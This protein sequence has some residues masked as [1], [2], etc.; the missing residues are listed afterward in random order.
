M[1][2]DLEPGGEIPGYHENY[3]LRQDRY[4]NLFMENFWPREVIRRVLIPFLVTRQLFAG[5]GA[6]VSD[7]TDV[8]FELSQRA[9]WIETVFNYTA[10]H[11][12]PIL[13][14]KR[15]DLSEKYLRVH[16]SCGDPNIT[17]WSTF[18]KI[19]TTAVIL[20]CLGQGVFSDVDLELTDSIQAFKTISRKGPVALNLKAGGQISA[21]DIQETLLQK[22]RGVD[23]RIVRPRDLEWEPITEV[24]GDTEKVQ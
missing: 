21:I 3:G 6:L 14:L 13:Q 24:W 23:D 15:P 19:G 2:S 7:G 4:F 5:A 22:V 8:H 1:I 16:I 17:E 11:R 9:R 10:S 18:L 12:R 20:A